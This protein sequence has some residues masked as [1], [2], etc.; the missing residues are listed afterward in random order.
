MPVTHDELRRLARPVKRGPGVDK[1][2]AFYLRPAMRVRSRKAVAVQACPD[3]N[4]AQD[5]R[6][7]ARLAEEQSP[8]APCLATALVIVLATLEVISYIH[9]VL[10]AAAFSYIRKV[11]PLS[12][13][14][15]RT[16]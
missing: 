14:P 3:F 5:H 8:H 12:S 13:T 9:E 1:L 2:T 16:P 7:F 11:W 6:R 10:A 4:P 15:P